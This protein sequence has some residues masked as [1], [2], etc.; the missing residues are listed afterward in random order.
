MKRSR[1]ATEEQY[2]LPCLVGF[3]LGCGA[4]SQSHSQWQF[5]RKTSANTQGPKPQT[6]NSCNRSPASCNLL[7]LHLHGPL[8]ANDAPEA[9]ESTKCFSAWA[10]MWIWAFGHRNG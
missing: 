8:T 10:K 7:Q 1:V 3:M 6:C 4:V 2:P 5:G 9:G